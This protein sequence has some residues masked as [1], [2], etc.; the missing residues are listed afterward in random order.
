M[1]ISFSTTAAA[2][3][4]AALS[5]SVLAAHR[6]FMDFLNHVADVC[7]ESSPLDLTPTQ[8]PSYVRVLTCYFPTTINERE[9]LSFVELLFDYVCKREE[10][11]RL[12]S[13]TTPT[14]ILY[15]NSAFFSFT[16]PILAS[17]ACL[18]SPCFFRTSLHRSL[19][20]RHRE[21]FPGLRHLPRDT[22]PAAIRLRFLLIKRLN[23]LLTELLPLID[24]RRCVC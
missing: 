9:L 22:S 17:N 4:V 18:T 6:S 3:A 15:A 16:L 10:G 2:A 19:T 23:T 13:T 24:L 14:P 12:I 1:R 7:G 8:I 20:A 5:P 21:M 11:M